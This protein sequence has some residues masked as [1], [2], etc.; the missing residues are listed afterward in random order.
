MKH[1]TIVSPCFNEEEN[2]EE[3]YARV[4][5]AM[6]RC[7]AFTFDLLFIDNAS[8]DRT[9]ELLR[10]L[11]AKDARVRVIVN[12]RNFGHIRSPYY[13][14]LQGEGDA[15][16]SI[17]SDLQDPPE[18]IPDFIAKWEAGF[19][20]VMGVKSRSEESILFYA[21]RSAYYRILHRLAEIE[22]VEHFTGFGLYDR[23]VM[24]VLRSIS[25]PYPYFRGL[26]ADIGFAS[27][28]I[29]FLQPGRKRG[30]TKNN[31]Y[32]LFDMAMLGFTNH[33]KVPLRMATLLGFLSGGLSFLIGLFYLGYKL[34]NWNSFSVGMAPLVI[35]L[36]FFAS[37]QLV[38]LGIV[39][40]Y[41][42]AIHTQVLNRP[43]VV[44]KE[45]INFGGDAPGRPS[46][47]S[48]PTQIR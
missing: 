16:I 20:V 4:V 13:G 11:A 42:G 48:P 18:L 39:G 1:L 47:D 32:T 15:V 17:A 36:F 7:P 19:K 38:F 26:I 33:S 25:D 22:L 12:A 43:L 23:Q 41:V 5:A 45:R 8:T 14:L 3:L 29:E 28:K 37:L 24:E 35:G 40:E 6:S 9:V 44:E 2:V 27:A 34:A 46:Q 21:L 10:G 31:F 30:L